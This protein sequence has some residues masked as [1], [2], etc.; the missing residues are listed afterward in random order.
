LGGAITG[1][2]P[3]IAVALTA[4]GGWQLAAAYFVFACLVSCVCIYVTKENFRR[5]FREV[6]S[7]Q[8]GVV[9][10]QGA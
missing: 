1:F 4:A 3:L 5:D 2:T 10:E 6:E 9:A 8:R 7:E